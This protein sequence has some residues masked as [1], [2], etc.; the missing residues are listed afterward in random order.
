MEQESLVTIQ[1]LVSDV[2]WKKAFSV[3]KELHTA[4]N[5]ERYWRLT[6]V[7]RKEGYKMFALFE[8]D[9][10]VSIAGVIVLTSLYNGKYLWVHDLITTASK[11]S[12]GYGKRLVSFMEQWAKENNCETVALSSG[13][14]RADAHRFYEDKM[15]FE[16]TSYVFKKELQ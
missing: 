14:Q 3:M 2:Q 15:G 7:M 6:A 1:E 11:R 13:L 12:Q 16:K 5:D 4:L 10:I 9:E 8:N